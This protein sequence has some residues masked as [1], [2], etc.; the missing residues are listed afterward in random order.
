[1][2]VKTPMSIRTEYKGVVFRS[3]LEADWAITFDTLGVEWQYEPQGKYYGT[4]FYLPDFI[5]PRSHQ[6]VEVK[7]CWDTD[8]QLKGEAYCAHTPP[9]PYNWDWHPDP[10]ILLVVA[11]PHGRMWPF[12]SRHSED[13]ALYQ[14]AACEGWWFLDESQGWRCRCCGAYDGDRFIQD[15]VSFPITPF[16]LFPG[17]R[18]NGWE[19]L[20]NG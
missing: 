9:L 17:F 1:M 7:G 12:G 4:Q 19:G 3:K 16:P 15:W 14:C 13:F 2:Y 8:A 11:E 18:S 6:A 5:L 20:A 10:D